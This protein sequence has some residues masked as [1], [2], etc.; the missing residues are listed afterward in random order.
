MGHTLHAGANTDIDHTGLDLVG[1]LGY[2]G[3]ARGT[4]A[5]E[6]VD[7]DGVGDTCGKGGHTCC[8]GTSTGRE[9]VADGDVADEGGVE[10]GGGVGVAED[11]HEK[12]FWTGV[13][14][15]TFLAL[16]ITP[17]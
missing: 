14:E 5:I 8:R 15:A 11:V 6:G 10:G 9:D 17:G 2:G 16:Y 4:L 12:F 7:G 3:E 13:F 1:D